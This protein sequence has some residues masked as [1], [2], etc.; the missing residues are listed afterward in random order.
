[1]KSF[2][3]AAVT[4]TVIM[5]SS[6]AFALPGAGGGGPPFGIPLEMD[7]FEVCP[8]VMPSCSAILGGTRTEVP[9]AP[10]GQP[11]DGFLVLLLSGQ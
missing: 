7:L 6:S 4:S 1:M 2:F 3:L 11:E 8:L 9:G 10:F 5:V